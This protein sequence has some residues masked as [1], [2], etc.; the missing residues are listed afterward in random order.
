MSAKTKIVVL[1][2]KELIYTGIFV[3]LAL[4]LVVIFLAMFR[5]DPDEKDNDHNQNVNVEAGG[6]RD[7]QTGLSVHSD[8]NVN[9]DAETAVIRYIPGVYTASL[10]LTSQSLDV[11]IIVDSSQIKSVRLLNLEESV[12]AMYPLMGPAM[13]SLRTQI[14]TNQSTEGIT[15]EDTSKYTTYVLLQAVQAALDKAVTTE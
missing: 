2:M 9:S 1:R 8:H 3:G 10:P 12:T 13:E 15:Y 7:A 6:E 5:S 14:L 4:L 11:E